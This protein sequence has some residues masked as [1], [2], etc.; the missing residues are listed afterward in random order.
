MPQALVATAVPPSTVDAEELHVWLGLPSASALHEGPHHGLWFGGVLL[1]VRGGDTQDEV[2]LG[3][4]LLV[5]LCY[6]PRCLAAIWAEGGRN[7]WRS[8]APFISAFGRHSARPVTE[9]ADTIPH[10]Q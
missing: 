4:V 1:E 7:I 8:R 10:T 2:A 6:G 3:E 5:A 9:S